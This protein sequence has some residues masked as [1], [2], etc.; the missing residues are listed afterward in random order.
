MAKLDQL[1]HILIVKPHPAS[2]QRLP[3]VQPSEVELESLVQSIHLGI[4]SEHVTEFRMLELQSI[5]IE[6]LASCCSG[7]IRI[8]NQ[9]HLPSSF[10]TGEYQQFNGMGMGFVVGVVR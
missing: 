3:S 9:S 2:E 1:L 10:R 6:G 8:E 4:S 7:A 5:S